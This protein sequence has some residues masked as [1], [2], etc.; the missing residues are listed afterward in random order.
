VQF[1]LEIGT[2]EIPAGYIEDGLQALKDLAETRLGEA[3]VKIGEGLQTLGTPRRLILLGRDVAPR[4]E[5]AVQEVTGPP[6]SAAYDAEGNPT[7]AAEGFARK[8]GVGLEDLGRVETPKGEYL[9]IKLE[10]SGRPTVE[11]LS[12]TLPGVIR[13]IPWPKSMRWGSGGFLFA[14]PIQWVLALLDGALIPFEVAD[15]KSGSMSRGHRFMAPDPFEVRGVDDLLEKLS[16]SS[17]VADP[18]ERKSKVAELVKRA[19]QSAGGMAVLDPALIAT[20]ANLVEYPSAVCG[21]FDRDFLELPDPVIIT[22]MAE[23]QK[24][25]A[26]RDPEGKL[27]PHFVAV[28]NTVARDETVVQRGHER[29]L[30]AR[31]SDAAFFFEE[32]RK[33]PLLDRLEDL[34]DVI[35][36]K[37]LGTSFEKVERSTRLALTVAQEVAPERTEEV[38][39]AARLAKCDLVT[40]MVSE[41]PSLQGIMGEVYSRLDGHAEE[42]C[43]AVREHYM[44]LR[45]GEEL[46]PGLPGA[47]VG[48]ADRMDTI[49]GCFAIGQEPTGAADPFA[50]RRHA[51]AV[52]RILEA[53]Q[54][55]L[56]LNDLTKKAL[57]GLSRKVSFD[58]EAV[59]GKV[60]AFLMERYRNRMLLRGHDA[61]MVDAV[62]SARFDRISRILPGIEHLERFAKSSAG[63]ESLVLTFKRV[64]N[65][66]KN[67]KTPYLVDPSLFKEPCEKSLW[68]KAEGLRG[69]I[70]DLVDRGE[71]EAA[72]GLLATLRGPVDEF[73]EGVEILT[74]EDQ[75]LRENRV[76]M[77]QRIEELFLGIADFSRIGG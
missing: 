42:I 25:F 16:G 7:K 51:L 66:L 45:A 31:L 61:G 11:V 33:R 9:H 21:G 6:L 36:Q 71:D 28:N 68:R 58:A 76:A 24:Y 38:G 70:V 67:E 12:E 50:L 55:D 27:M 46:P 49:A 26:V 59:R 57:E 32:D 29:V 19:A 17:V 48:V 43:R 35:Y 64:T 5:D 10:I 44:P 74:R 73:F 14:R 1:L 69:E 13:D 47:V 41:F 54:W 3:R 62:L 40:E 20:V 8:Y 4:Q 15:V 60:L 23:H 18:E 53:R 65:I 30:R 52:L 2:E 63:F 72:L 37:E 34:K 39:V 77:L 75:R 56:S 22:P